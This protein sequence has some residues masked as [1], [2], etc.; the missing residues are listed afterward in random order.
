[1]LQQMRLWKEE[2]RLAEI[3]RKKRIPG[4]FEA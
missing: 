4:D 1:V 2:T 3:D